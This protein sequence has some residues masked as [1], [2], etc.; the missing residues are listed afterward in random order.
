MVLLP[1][2]LRPSCTDGGK[3]LTYLR[4]KFGVVEWVIKIVRHRSRRIMHK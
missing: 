1:D 4:L 3:K 2:R